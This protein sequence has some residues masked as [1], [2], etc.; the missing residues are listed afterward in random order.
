[1]SAQQGL[2][3]FPHLINAPGQQL[4]LTL[5]VTHSDAVMQSSYTATVAVLDDSFQLLSIP[6]PSKTREGV[7]G[8][9]KVKVSKVKLGTLLFMSFYVCFD[10]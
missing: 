8:L 7:D 2:K 1:M 4:P 10:L 9:S 6:N 5:T 3:L